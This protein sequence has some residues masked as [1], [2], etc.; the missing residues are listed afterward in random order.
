M[1]T[2]FATLSI[3]SILALAGIASGQLTL[4][5]DAT[6]AP[7]RL[8]HATLEMPAEAGEM[9]VYYVEW[10][11]GNHNPSGP[12]Q[13]VVDFRVADHTGRE[14]EWKRDPTDVVR[15][16]F[17]VP[18]GAESVTLSYSYILNQPST[19]SR[20]TDSYGLRSMGVINWNTVLFEPGGADKDTL[21]VRTSL[22]LPGP[23]LL[24]SPL[25]QKLARG[26]HYEFEEVS[27]AY[28]VDS[29]AIFG[30]YLSTWEMN[31]PG[32]E[33]HFTDAVAS[34]PEKLKLSDGVR[35]KLDEMLAQTQAIFGPF[36]Y[37]R[38]HFLTVLENDIPGAGLEHTECTYI[39]YPDNRFTSDDASA[40]GTFPHEYIHAWNGKLRAPEGLL[41]RDYHTEARTELLWVYEGMTSY[42]DDVIM[43][44]SGMYTR[45][46][47]EDAITGYIE[48]YQ[49][50]TGRLWRSVED[51]ASAQRHLR[52]R[53]KYWQQL[54]RRQDYYG[55]GALFWMSADATIR[56]GTDNAKSLDD[57]ARAFFDVEP[58]AAGSPVTYTRADVVAGLTEVYPQA[59]WDAMIRDYIERPVETLEHPVLNLLNRDWAHS[60]EPSDKQE[61][62][63]TAPYS[64]LLKR[65][66]GF[67]TDSAG[68]V[69]T[70]LQGTP[71]DAA[72]MSYGM[73]VLG[74]DGWAFTPELIKDRLTHTEQTQRIDVVVR[75]D[76]RVEVRT[77]L[78]DG[79]L[80]YPRM[81]LREGAFDVL[82]AIIAPR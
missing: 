9:D 22:T 28:L 24:A 72:G 38:Y 53:G 50:Q 29:P 81:E 41:H 73:T 35:E 52:D 55:E 45:E 68:V 30:E 61:K 70:V 75:F 1:P 8:L 64:D 4:R 11:P 58:I 54:R 42:Y 44:R 74:V 77:I 23:W 12:I 80:K 32:G 47:Y 17:V 79:G 37:T 62:D 19:N 21:T 36:P 76:D 3:A 48:G 15:T 78:Y 13:N 5:V 14:L 65:T 51:T 10:T 33:P 2:R 16:S 18:E 43:A 20:S 63:E 71:A 40:L 49:L 56:S 69:T 67:A 46:E 59:D 57:F 25:P 82:G 60:A 27:F 31:S 34:A 7:R 39:S 66:L 26:G 6:D